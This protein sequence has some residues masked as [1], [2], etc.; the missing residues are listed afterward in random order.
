LPVAVVEEIFKARSKQIH[1]EHIEIAFNA[2]PVDEWDASL[3][4]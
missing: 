2:E 3:E 1:N 4:I